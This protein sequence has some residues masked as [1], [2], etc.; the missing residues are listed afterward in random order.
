MG[1]FLSDL[2]PEETLG[3]GVAAVSS[4]AQFATETVV[5]FLIFCCFHTPSI[6]EVCSQP[7]T[8]DSQGNH[9]IFHY[10]LCFKPVRTE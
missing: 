3:G 2:L 6:R 8:S 7:A 1:Y 5:P 4:Q 9:L 10:Y